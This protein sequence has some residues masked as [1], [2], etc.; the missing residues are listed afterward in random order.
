MAA[1]RGCPEEELGATRG[2]PT[3]AEPEDAAAEVPEAAVRPEELRG[4]AAPAAAAGI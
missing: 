3:E 2:A 1:A 4:V